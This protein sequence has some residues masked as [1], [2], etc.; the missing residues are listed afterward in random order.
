MS[1]LLKYELYLTK[2]QI[3]KVPFKHNLFCNVDI[4]TK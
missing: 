1:Y 2:P 3:D 4:L